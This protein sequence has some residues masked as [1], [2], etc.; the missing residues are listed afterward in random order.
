MAKRLPDFGSLELLVGVDDHG[1]LS[2]AS[3][4]VQVSQP[5]AS[6]A[7][8]RL[9]RQLGIT[10]LLR[11]TAGSTLTAQG[12]VI[13]HWARMVLA[14]TERLLDAALALS[15]E[16]AAE[17][18]VGASMTVAEHLMPHWLGVFRG[19]F[20]DVTIQLQVLNS[21]EVFERIA[22]NSCD[23]GFVESL[24]I[25]HGLHSAVVA[26]DRLVAVV[27]PAHPWA[28]RP[29]TLTVDELAAT[30]LLVRE[31]GSGTRDT[32][33]LALQEYDRA[34]PLLELGSAAAIRASALSG[35]GPAVLSTLAVADQVH[36]GDLRL[37]EVDGLDLSRA[38][39]AVWRSPRQLPGPAGE[40][41]R[42]ARQ[43][44][45]TDAVWMGYQPIAYRDGQSGPAH[46]LN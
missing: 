32:L 23:V 16:R 17:L 44:V 41:V 45:V 7:I 21:A 43:E 34:V 9:E 35:V 2:A 14:D 28:H 33:D 38:L 25:P 30:P 37:I 46:Q 26:R 31:P 8:S 3:R 40:L 6:R 24:T 11:S 19:I 4:K 18:V 42:L 5:N 27:H 15:V 36:S 12:T 10:L 29:K 22:D 13:A 20:S 39:R 1:S